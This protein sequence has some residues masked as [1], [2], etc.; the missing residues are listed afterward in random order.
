[1]TA[2]RMILPPSAV[3]CCKCEEEAIKRAAE[4]RPLA[5]SSQKSV[6]FYRATPVVEASSLL[7]LLAAPIN[8][9]VVRPKKYFQASNEL[10][11]LTLIICWSITLLYNPEAALQHPARQYVGHFNPCGATCV[12]DC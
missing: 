4:R 10:V 11:M 8:S 7:K 3:I 6:R 1:M 9:A 2:N 12:S 5:A